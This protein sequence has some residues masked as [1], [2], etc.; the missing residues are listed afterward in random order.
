MSIH[1]ANSK[2]TPEELAALSK[3]A[4]ASFEIWFLEHEDYPDG[5]MNCVENRIAGS[6]TEL[7]IGFTP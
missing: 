4:G 1:F 7:L 5:V 3:P 6:L 2:P